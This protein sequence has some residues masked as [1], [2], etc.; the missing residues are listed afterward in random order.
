MSLA[1]FVARRYLRAKRKQAFIGVI[2]LITLIGITLGTAALNVALSI[3]NGMRGAFMESLIGETGTLY[4]VSRQ[5]F[6][7]D[8]P[9]E[10]TRRLKEGFSPDDLATVTRILSATKGVKA[11]TLM[12][13]DPGVIFAPGSRVRFARI[14]AI[15]P[16]TFR[17]AS[18]KLDNMTSGSLE[19][20]ATRPPGTRPGIVV[21]RDLARNLGVVVGDEIQLAIGKLRSAGLSRSHGLRLRELRCEVVGIFQTGNSQFDELEV[22]ITHASA[23]RLVSTDRI[24]SVLVS[25]D[26]VKSM[27]AAK[28]TLRAHPELPITTTIIDFRDLNAGLLE[29]LAL[30]KAATTAVIALFI[31]VVAL[32]MIS[33]LIMMVMEKHRDIGIMK[34]FGAPRALIR[35]IFVRQG[36]VL[37]VIGTL[38]G[39][40]LGVGGAVFADQTRLFR[41]DNRVYEVLSYLPFDVRPIEVIAVASGSLLLTFLTT[42]YPAHQAARLDPVEALKYD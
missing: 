3:H 18:N 1:G 42:L 29:A 28:E 12:R 35:A 21:G 4:L 19:M 8:L 33:A 2:S 32:N 34:S 25:F 37:S 40:V 30:E 10:E 27:D 5:A 6:F 14:Q 38:L 9:E 13:E 24:G 20:L 41:L 15:D 23:F 36:M 16:N 31:L 17:N 26:S 39:T 7:D 22:Y 11:W